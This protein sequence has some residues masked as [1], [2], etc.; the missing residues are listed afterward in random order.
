MWISKDVDLPESLID[1]QRKGQLVVF[2]GAGVSMGEPSNLPSFRTLAEQIGRLT[3]ALEE[4]EA[5]DLYLG[6]VEDL[7]ARVQHLALMAIDAPG[8][9][10]RELHRDLLRLF[11]NAECVR[12]VT[13]NFDSHFSKAAVSV[14]DAPVETF[15]APALPL[16]RDFA[17][18]AYLHGAVAKPRNRLVLTDR[19]FGQAYVTEGWATRFLVEV[20]ENFSVLFVGYSHS[21]PVMGYLSRSIRGTRDRYMLT[22][23]DQDDKWKRLGIQPVHFPERTGEDTFGALDQGVHGWADL[24]KMGALDHE[25]RLRSIVSGTPVLDPQTAD[26]VRI[27][28]GDPMTVRFFVE[29]AKTP[30]WLHWV[31]DAGFFKALFS[32]NVQLER[33]EKT[34]A[35]WFANA[36]AV[37]YARDAL[38]LVA[39]HGGRLCTELWNAVAW[40]LAT[41][42]S[43]APEAVMHKWIVVL[44]ASASDDGPD[45]VLSY[46]LERCAKEHYTI[47][48]R[49]LLE[50]LTRPAIKTEKPWPLGEDDEEPRIRISITAM[51]ESHHLHQAWEKHF[52]PRLDQEG[53]FLKHVLASSVALAHEL[54]MAESDGGFDASNFK[55]SAIEA[56]AQDEF[57]D[58]FGFV[59]SALRDVLDHWLAKSPE[60]TKGWINEWLVADSPVLRRLALHGLAEDPTLS[61][62]ETLQRIAREG[63]LY[64]RGLKHEV[65]T[66]LKARFPGASET[67]KQAFIDYSMGSQVIDGQDADL[68]RRGIRDYERYNVAAW[69]TMVA[70]DSAVARQHFQALQTAHPDFGVRDHPDFDSWSGGASW[71]T[72]TSPVS[73]DDLLKD[74][75]EVNLPLLLTFDGERQRFDG[76]TRGGL[77]Q[78]LREAVGKSFE[79]TLQ[80]TDTL[81]ARNEW[82]SSVWEAVLEAWKQSAL[83]E[84]QLYKVSSRLV[85]WPEISKGVPRELADFV[86]SAADK[87][88][89]LQPAT[90]DNLE[91]LA[92]ASLESVAGADGIGIGERPEWLTIAINHPNGRAVIAMLQLL[93]KRRAAKRGHPHELTEP[94]KSAFQTVIARSDVGAERART[95]LT[96][97]TH[98]L[99]AIDPA[100]TRINILPLFEWRKNELTAEQAWHGYIGWGQWNEALLA[101]F[102]PL[103]SETFGRL[104]T[105]LAGVAD[106]FARRLVGIALYSATD[107]WHSGWLTDFVRNADERSRGLWSTYMTGSLEKLSDEAKVT[108]WDRWLHDYW[109]DRVLGVPRPLTSEENSSMLDWT[110]SL[111]PVISAAIDR[112]CSAPAPLTERAMFFYGLRQSD[113]VSKHPSDALKLVDHVLRSSESI[114]YE[115]SYA[116]EVVQRLHGLVAE[117]DRFRSIAESLAR[118]SCGNPDELRRLAT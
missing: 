38:D 27:A 116:L 68:E 45:R 57:E 37:D 31:S 73:A 92:V 84:D 47:S 32:Q 104:G 58:S 24:A 118:L 102:L 100:W 69:L 8:S 15:Y 97:Q 93:S 103:F 77:L 1:A 90:L 42:E 107:P 36:Y 99:F 70:P 89:T 83:T 43:A 4:N 96:S 101:A 71:V 75:P 33:K 61:S 67:E 72:E 30:D 91:K 114:W 108:L 10:F 74:A 11:E 29:N 25:Q 22:L 65:F 28:L 48:S 17:G 80:L 41:R 9:T 98:F 6:R 60:I 63:V 81:A 7:G 88:Q 76:P 66:V 105:N 40:H 5:L 3:A 87:N 26:Y 23:P 115:C 53:V 111:E 113:I 54:R 85:S 94:Y 112:V 18:I 16:G 13:T 34:L 95:V 106:S 55:R 56:H 109:K 78:A 59:I 79:W 12:I 86:E 21:D 52:V 14:F 2:A 44:L 19:D 51:G 49:L 64:R 35:Y 46:L 50:Y 39:Q 117:R 82:D 62:D 110:L 20:F